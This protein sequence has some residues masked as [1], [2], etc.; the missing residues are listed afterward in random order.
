MFKNPERY[1]MWG[2]LFFK[3]AAE[4]RK[5]EVETFFTRL[6]QRVMPKS[7]IQ[8][9]GEITIARK[10]FENYA[11]DNVRILVRSFG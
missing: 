11:G 1:T 5:P 9:K 6:I 7:T 4:L 3:I 10:F 8:S 2:D